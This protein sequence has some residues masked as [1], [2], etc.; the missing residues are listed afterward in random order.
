MYVKKL[1][2]IVTNSDRGTECL[3]VFL[4]LW[5]KKRTEDNLYNCMYMYLNSKSLFC[6]DCVHVHVFEFEELIL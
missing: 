3:R 4:Y 2:M 6:S 5:A 1:Q